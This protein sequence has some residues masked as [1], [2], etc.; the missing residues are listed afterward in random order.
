MRSASRD[1]PLGVRCNMANQHSTGLKAGSGIARGEQGPEQ[2]MERGPE[3]GQ[4]L[5]S[6][7]QFEQFRR[8]EKGMSIG[9]REALISQLLGECWR[10]ISI[11]SGV[12]SLGYQLMTH[13]YG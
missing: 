13:W 12:R 7:R 1:N 5:S 4:G 9:R 11:V 2:G 6:Q 8:L 3:R 10:A